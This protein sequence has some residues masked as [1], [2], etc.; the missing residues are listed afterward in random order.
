MCVR[1]C[2]MCMHVCPRV[3]STQSQN[4][5]AERHVGARNTNCSSQ[6]QHLGVLGPS[7]GGNRAQKPKGASS[8]AK[9]SARRWS[10]SGQIV[11]G[12]QGHSR[13]HEMQPEDSDVGV[14]AMGA[15]VNVWCGRTH[16]GGGSL[17]QNTGMSSPV[18]LSGAVKENRA[19][20]GVRGVGQGWVRGRDP[21]GAQQPP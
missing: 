4:Q 19:L 6:G 10:G 7:L 18:E 1:V 3:A 8:R 21:R 12:G 9:G 15:C 2:P 20:G 14:E 13:G 5:R 17:R 16:G 11:E